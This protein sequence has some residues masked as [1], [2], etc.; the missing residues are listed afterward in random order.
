M[1][2]GAPR[3]HRPPTHPPPATFPRQHKLIVP[4][5]HEIDGLAGCR[6]SKL[7]RQRQSGSKAAPQH[8]WRQ[9]LLLTLAIGKGRLPSKD[10]MSYEK[11]SLR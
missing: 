7:M 2:R 6:D 5:R 8:C 3:H 11:E 4:L 1:R 9:H 10:Y